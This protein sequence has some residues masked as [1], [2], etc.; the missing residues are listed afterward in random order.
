MPTAMS[1][2]PALIARCAAAFARA[3]RPP[4]SRAIR[5]GRSRYGGA[6]S[7]IGVALSVGNL[8]GHSGAHVWTQEFGS[9]CGAAPLGEYQT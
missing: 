5:I 6:H 9:H 8:E 4:R 2:S 1:T 7:Q 3:P